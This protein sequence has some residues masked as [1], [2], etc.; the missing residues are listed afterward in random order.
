MTQIKGIS[1]GGYRVLKLIEEFEEK[2]KGYIKEHQTSQIEYN[3]IIKAFS[4]VIQE[5]A[6]IKDSAPVVMPPV[7]ANDQP[8]EQKAS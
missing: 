5:I 7:H 3:G 8:E 2:V 6:K 4:W 1:K